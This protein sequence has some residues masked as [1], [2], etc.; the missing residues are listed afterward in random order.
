MQKIK[1]KFLPKGV[2]LAH[3]QKVKLIHNADFSADTIDSYQPTEKIRHFLCHYTLAKGSD[4]PSKHPRF[5]FLKS[6]YDRL[7]KKDQFIELTLTYDF[8]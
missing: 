8:D 6:E 2:F 7:I 3:S 4:G 1:L 5:L